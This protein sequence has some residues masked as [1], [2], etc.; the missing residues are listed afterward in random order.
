MIRLTYLMLET[1]DNGYGA[2]SRSNIIA[3]SLSV[4]S[5]LKNETY[6]TFHRTHETIS[7]IIGD[8]SFL[9]GK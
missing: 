3:L 2:M 5:S 9:V 8:R 7:G 6:M 4:T 1:N